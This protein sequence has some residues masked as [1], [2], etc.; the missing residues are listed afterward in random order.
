VVAAV[1]AAIRFQM[2]NQVLLADQAL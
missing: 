2:D 1:V